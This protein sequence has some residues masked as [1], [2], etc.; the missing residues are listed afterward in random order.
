M[1]QELTKVPSSGGKVE[2]GFKNNQN[3][4]TDQTSVFGSVIITLA[5][6]LKATKKRTLLNEEKKANHNSVPKKVVP[7]FFSERA[8]LR[9]SCTSSPVRQP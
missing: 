3:N 1:V 2:T 6:F 4:G 9:I 7:F 8:E 5:L